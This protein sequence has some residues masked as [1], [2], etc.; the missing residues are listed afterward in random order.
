MACMTRILQ[1]MIC[2]AS[3]YPVS[4]LIWAFEPFFRTLK[5]A[6]ARRTHDTKDKNDLSNSPQF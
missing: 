4:T 6:L 3:I 2:Q 5:T 1:A